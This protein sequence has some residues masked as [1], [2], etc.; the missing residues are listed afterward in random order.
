MDLHCGIHLSE[1]KKDCSAE[2]RVCCELKNPL[3]QQMSKSCQLFPVILPF[4]NG[5]KEFYRGGLNF[6]KEALRKLKESKE[7]SSFSFLLSARI[8]Q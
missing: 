4:S 8:N 5:K 7:F 2:I 1:I 6:I 3:L